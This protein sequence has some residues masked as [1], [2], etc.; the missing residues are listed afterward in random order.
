MER[1]KERRWRKGQRERTRR[2]HILINGERY[3]DTAKK[4][5]GWG[6]QQSVT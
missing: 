4:G 1:K 2:Q 5:F 3:I 6:R